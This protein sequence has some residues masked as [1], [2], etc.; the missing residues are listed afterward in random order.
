MAPIQEDFIF[1]GLWP[2]TQE[3]RYEKYENAER[4][5]TAQY[6]PRNLR[7]QMEEE[8]KGGDI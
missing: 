5:Y 3:H 1:Y 7:V 2:S 8:Q 6:T 4:V